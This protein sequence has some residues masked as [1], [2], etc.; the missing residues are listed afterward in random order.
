MKPRYSP[1][2]TWQFNTDLT[3]GGG[4]FK[5]EITPYV[6]ERRDLDCA[7]PHVL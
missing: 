7:F 5:Y 2:L 6:H 1:F 4:S 3:Q